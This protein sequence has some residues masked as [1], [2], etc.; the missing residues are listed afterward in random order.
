MVNAKTI[1]IPFFHENILKDE[2][3]KD[4]VRKQISPVLSLCKE[5]NIRLGI[6]TEIKAEELLEFIKSFNN[7]QIGSYY[8]IGNMVSIGVDVTKEI[9]LLGKHIY[10]VHIKDRMANGGAT[11]PLG[12]GCAN[13]EGAFNTLKEIGY[14]EP[15]IIHGARKTDNDDIELNREYFNFTKQILEKIY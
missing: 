4:F 12:N 9:K 13:F 5:L 6:E 15:L 7:P 8:D 11:I 3:D 2:E 14:N 10:S 1:L